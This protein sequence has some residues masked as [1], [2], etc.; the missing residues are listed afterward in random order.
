MDYIK[1]QIADGVELI[2]VEA[3]RFKTNEI[4]VSF[5]LPLERNSASANALTVGMLSRKSKAYPD[6]KSLNRKLAELYG[7]T[8]LATVSKVGECQV[9]KLGVTALDERFS[10]DGESIALECVRLLTSLIFEP[11]LDGDGGFYEEDI[12]SE[13]RLLIE[14]ISAE[15]NEKRIYVLR[16]TEELMFENEPYGINRY[17]TIN[18]VEALTGEDVLAAWRN[19]LSR[20]KIMVTVIGK[21]DMEKITAHLTECFAG[22]ERKYFDLPKAVFVP[23]ADKVKEKLERIDVNQGK[24]VM[25][26]RVDLKP[27]SSLAPAMR[28][29]C[30]IFGGGPYSKLF[31]NV[32]EKM[33]LCYYCSARYTR[34]KS[35]IMIQCG[36]NEENMDKAVNEILNQLEIIKKGDFDEEFAS[37]KMALRDGILAVNDAPEVMENWY[38]S[39]MTDDIIKSPAVSVAEND[40]VTKAQVMECA[41]LLTLD[42]VYR[43]TA[44]EGAES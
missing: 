14:K 17:G 2:G 12:A 36:C 39:Q 18:Q 24:L 33:S 9:M 3:D 6:M 1:T 32:R 43:L 38:S 11:K 40:S 19:M 21:T 42:T 5:A 20:A 44:L 13:K 29:F 26:F 10:L 27:D 7:A 41:G 28:T 30:D 4:A 35:Y 8:L 22:I 23:K 15:D 31:A 16:K 37:S 25:G 34:L